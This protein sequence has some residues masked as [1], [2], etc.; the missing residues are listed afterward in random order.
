[1]PTLKNAKHERFAQEVASGKKLEEAHELAGYKPDRGTASKLRQTTSIS[2][3]VSELLAEREQIH[4]QATA[5]AIERAGLTK[6]WVITRLRENAERA[7]QAIPVLDSEGAPTGE[8]RYEGSVANRALE[9]LGKELG[10]FIER[11]EIGQPGDFDKMSDDELRAEL[12]ALVASA[13]SGNDAE[14]EGAKR[15]RDTSKLN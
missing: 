4:G 12:G 9:L 5:Q 6:E 14:G 1:M 10:M 8:Y 3:R 7:L 2:Q 13:T 11:K 15:P